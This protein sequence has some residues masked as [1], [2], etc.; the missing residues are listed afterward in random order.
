MKGTHV[1]LDALAGLC[2]REWRLA[3]VGDGP[4]RGALEDQS[5]RLNLSDRVSF[6]GRV[7]EA[8]LPLYFAAADVFVYPELSQPAFGLV[9]LEALLQGTPVVANRVGAVPEVVG[10]GAGELID[11]FGSGDS[12]RSVLGKW[13]DEKTWTTF[14]TAALRA[15]ALKRFSYD[16]MIDGT[17]AVYEG[18]IKNNEPLIYTNL[19]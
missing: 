16:A 3:I 2:E 17:L 9:A 19:H 13:L 1:L 7:A 4:E 10:D 11:F 8:E 6:E 5:R 15:A 18:I 12:W 14:D